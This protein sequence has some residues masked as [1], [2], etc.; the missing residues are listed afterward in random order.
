MADKNGADKKIIRCFSFLH[1]AGRQD[2]SDDPEH[3]YRSLGIIEQIKDKLSLSQDQYQKLLIAVKEHNK[4]EAK[5][6]DVTIR[7]CWDADRLDLF[8][9]G[10]IP[11][12][13]YLYTKEGADYLDLIKNDIHI[14]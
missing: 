3:S 2:D 4:K 10:I 7:T 6:D 1:D 12:K 5:S 8:R 14:Q 11:D 9:V 13:K